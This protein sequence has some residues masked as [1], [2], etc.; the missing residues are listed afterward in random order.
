MDLRE[1]LKEK[2]QPEKS[3]EAPSETNTLQ[4][5]NLQSSTD[6]E[7]VAPANMTAPPAT[8]EGRL[9]GGRERERETERESQC[10]GVDVQVLGE[11][12]EKNKQ[13]D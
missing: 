8:N 5:V 10:G 6:T 13:T 3:T 11:N 7:Q 1:L 4:S 9:K 2:V 12:Y